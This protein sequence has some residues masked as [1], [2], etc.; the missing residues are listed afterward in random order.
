MSRDSSK[1]T[2]QDASRQHLAFRKG[3]IEKCDCQVCYKNTP[4]RQRSRE[5]KKLENC[6]FHKCTNTGDPEGEGILTRD[7]YGSSTWYC[8]VSC[9]CMDKMS[10]GSKDMDPSLYKRMLEE[11]YTQKRV[12]IGETD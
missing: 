10:Q 9:S 12:Y 5:N 1:Q 2:S 7:N 3:L 6:S 4:F 8:S 11:V